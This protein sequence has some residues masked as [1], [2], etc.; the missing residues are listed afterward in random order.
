M[1]DLAKL[2]YSEWKDKIE[3]GLTVIEK[4]QLDKCLEQ[5]GLTIV[6]IL[7]KE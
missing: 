4:F 5:H 3:K 2:I 7:E 1:S 6:E